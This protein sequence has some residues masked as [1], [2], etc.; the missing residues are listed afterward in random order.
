MWRTGGIAVLYISIKLVFNEK[1][2][3]N[4]NKKWKNF[5][6]KCY[7]DLLNICKSPGSSLDGIFQMTGPAYLFA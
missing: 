1:K 5:Y 2:Y 7:C 6:K 3:E 4:D